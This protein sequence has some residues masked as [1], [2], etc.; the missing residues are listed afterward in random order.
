[1]ADVVSWNGGG[2][3]KYIIKKFKGMLLSIYTSTQSETMTYA[4]TNNSS[5]NIFTGIVEDYDDATGILQLRSEKSGK[6]FWIQEWYVELFWL[7]DFDPREVMSSSKSTHA[8]IV[9]E[10][11][12]RSR[13]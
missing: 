9:K 4:D 7:P 6:P 5:Q 3:G 1:M 13:K 12:K 8:V 11:A 2:S 10:Q